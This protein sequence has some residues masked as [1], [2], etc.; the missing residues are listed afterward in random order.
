[1]S[2]ILATKFMN[3]TTYPYHLTER[4]HK[5]CHV[6]RSIDR[7]R[8][9]VDP[10]LPLACVAVVSVTFPSSQAGQA[11]E[12]IRQKLKKE[13][14]SRSGGPPAPL[15]LLFAQCPRALTLTC[16]QSPYFSVGLR[17]DG[18]AAI[19]VRKSDRDLGRVSKLPRGAG[20]G[21]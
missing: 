3:I 10:S 15:P 7:Y 19:L 4:Q 2:K 12:G 13:Q 11:R 21:V 8:S 1:M 18:T 20:V 14:K 5:L 17:L 16:P 6:I 9:A